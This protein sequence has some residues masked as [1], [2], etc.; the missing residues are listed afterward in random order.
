MHVLTKVATVVNVDSIFDDTDK[1]Y[2][3][4]FCRDSSHAMFRNGAS[5]VHEEGGGTQQVALI[6]GQVQGLQHDLQQFIQVSQAAIMDQ[7]LAGGQLQSQIAQIQSERA[8][9]AQTRGLPAPAAAPAP[10]PPLPAPPQVAVVQQPGVC[11]GFAPAHLAQSAGLQPQL[12]AAASPSPALVPATAAAAPAPVTPPASA[13]VIPSIEEQQRAVHWQ[14]AELHQHSATL[15]ALAAQAAGAGVAGQ[16]G[17]SGL[18]AMADDASINTRVPSLPPSPVDMA[19]RKPQ[20]RLFPPRSGPA[21]HG[22]P[23]RGRS[24]A[25]ALGLLRLP[26]VPRRVMVA[27]PPGGPSSS[28]R[29]RPAHRPVLTSPD[30]AEL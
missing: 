28:P 3:M 1:F 19:K 27:A 23:R 29:L 17:P 2:A 15:Q 10:P 5:V 24:A 13:G 30:A 25:P 8:G 18:D 9:P 11:V 7:Q 21:A 14:M 12:G 16:A 22:Q 4:Q 26:R 20:S 6:Q